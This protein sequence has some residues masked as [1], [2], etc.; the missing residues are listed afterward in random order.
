VSFRDRS[1]AGRKLAELLRPLADHDVVVLALP[2][3][4]LPVAAEVASAL[5]APLDVVVVRKLG[6]P[7][8][9]ELA[10]GAVGED[11]V[12]VWND[13]VRRVA[14]VSD[15][16]ANDVLDR[17]SAEVAR[18]AVWMRGQGEHRVPVGGRTAIVIDD[19]IA[20]GSTMTAACRIVRAH[21]AARIV[22][23][24][25]V[26]AADVVTT[27]RREAD[28]VVAVSTPSRLSSV[29]GWYDDFTQVSDDEVR[30]LLAQS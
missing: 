12:V 4:G 7:R 19:G 26:V 8:Q 27:L 23:A 18:R 13:D 11:G 25:P 15:A 6:V 9:P 14:R 30:R 17:E 21:G 22:V 16:E 28:D 10:M 5:G 1:D 3:G 24:V 2:R 29:G 20:T